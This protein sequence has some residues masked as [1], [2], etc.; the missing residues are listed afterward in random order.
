M[1]M[2]TLLIPLPASNSCGG[3][4]S[5]ATPVVF[6]SYRWLC[7][8]C[9]LLLLFMLA[10]WPQWHCPYLVYFL[11]RWWLL[12]PWTSNLI[13]WL[14]RCVEEGGRCALLPLLRFVPMVIL[15]LSVSLPLPVH[16]RLLPMVT[17]TLLAVLLP[18]TSSLISWLVVLCSMLRPSVV[19]RIAGLFFLC[20]LST[21]VHRSVVQPISV[22]G[23]CY[24]R[25]PSVPVVLGGLG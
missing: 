25:L 23:C 4:N 13:S 12:L 24:I 3:Y 7:K 11:F 16:C 20:H 2:L 14:V 17:L 8:H 22:G 6:V 9:R 21:G 18:W 10:G 1:V 15:T 19:D 5:T